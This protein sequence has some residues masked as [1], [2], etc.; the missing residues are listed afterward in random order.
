MSGGEL[1]IADVGTGS[2]VIAICCAKHLP[3][4]AVTAFDISAAALEVAKRNAAKHDVTGQVEFVESDLFAERAVSP[5]FDLI[6]SNPPYVAAEEMATL[7]TDVRNYEPHLALDGGVQGTEVIERL[8]PQ[9]VERLRP[10][11]W[12]L[13]EVGPG[14]AEQVGQLVDEAAGITRRETI[15]DLAGLPRVVQGQRSDS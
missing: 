6:L 2:G 5:E 12:L 1:R 11:G 3:D 13:M 10:G 8:I 15:S 14:N 7:E 9:A 4:C